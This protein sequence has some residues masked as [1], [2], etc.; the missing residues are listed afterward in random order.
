MCGTHLPE[1]K[2][3]DSAYTGILP[4]VT[5]PSSMFHAHGPGYETTHHRWSQFRISW[6]SCYFQWAE[7]EIGNTWLACET[8]KKLQ[9]ELVCLS[10]SLA[11]S[12]GHTHLPLLSPSNTIWILAHKAQLCNSWCNQLR[13]NLMTNTATIAQLIILFNVMLPRYQLHTN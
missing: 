4:S 6:A 8:A 5:R 2:T 3:A 1:V 10:C 12:P 13:I 7:W 9:P 11:S